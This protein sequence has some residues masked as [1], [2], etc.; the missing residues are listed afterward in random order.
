MTARSLGLE[1]FP[2]QKKI[3]NLKYI[4]KTPWEAMKVCRGNR[5]ITLLLL[6]LGTR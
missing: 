6:N 2:I 1:L 5:D 3:K 4:L